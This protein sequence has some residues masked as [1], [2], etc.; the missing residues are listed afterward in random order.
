MIGAPLYAAHFSFGCPQWQVRPLLS[1]DEAGFV[2]LYQDARV[3][4]FIGPVLDAEL[5]RA[6]LQSCLAANLLPAGK[7][8]LSVLSAGRMLGLLALNWPVPAEPAVELGIVLSS[9]GQR[10]RLA[11]PVFQGLM[12]QVFRCG[13]QRVDACIHRDNLAA[14]RLARQCGLTLLM[15]SAGHTREQLCFSALAA[16]LRPAPSCAAVAASAGEISAVDGPV[17]TS[18]CFAPHKAVK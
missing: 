15:H 17:D 11:Q 14:L 8:Y 2:S 13:L 9:E 18:G 1:A 6:L 4:L 16:A 3:Q 5:A 10:R 12:Q 7:A